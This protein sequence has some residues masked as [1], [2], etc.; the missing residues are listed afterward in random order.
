MER[1]RYDECGRRTE[2]HFLQ[3][4]GGVAFCLALEDFYNWEDT[5]DMCGNCPFYKTDEQYE[6]GLLLS[7][8]DGAYEKRTA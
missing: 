8:K 2:C 1:I 7:R 5:R 4:R 3:K 6:A